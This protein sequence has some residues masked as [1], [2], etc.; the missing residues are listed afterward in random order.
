[1]VKYNVINT[2]TAYVFMARYFNGE[3]QDFA[4]E[5]CSC[6]SN[7]SL[8][9]KMNHNFED[10]ATAVESVHCQIISVSF[11]YLKLFFFLIICL[12]NNSWIHA[13]QENIEGMREDIHKVL[14]GPH[15][16][17]VKYYI[18]AALSDIHKLIDIAISDCAMKKD[19]TF[20]L[21]FPD[22]SF[23]T[24]LLDTKHKLKVHQKKIEYFLSYVK[25]CWQHV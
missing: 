12:Q 6:M 8:C 9:L 14:K 18:F 5:A 4:R 16:S 10:F 25:D 22:S 24:V 1:M 21:R 7:L 15:R 13:D 20:A 3:Y 2:L 19:K 11:L 17:E 23:P